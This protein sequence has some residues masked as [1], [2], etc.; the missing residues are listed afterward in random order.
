MDGAEVRCIASHHLWNEKKYGT[1]ALDIKCLFIFLIKPAFTIN[2][3]LVYFNG[4]IL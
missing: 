1:F 3:Y 2:A 4:T